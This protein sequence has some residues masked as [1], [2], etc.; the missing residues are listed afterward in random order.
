[1]TTSTFFEC[2]LR[3]KVLQQRLDE[4]V[5]VTDYNDR[6]RTLQ[7]IGAEAQVLN[8]SFLDQFI[9][10]ELNEAAEKANEAAKLCGK[11]R[12]YAK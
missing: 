7:A 9:I 8:R 4:A 2:A 3:L 12:S 10:N 6:I 5:C 11:A 1:M